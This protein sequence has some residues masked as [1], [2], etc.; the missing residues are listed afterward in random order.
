MMTGRTLLAIRHIAFEDLGSY[1]APLPQAGCDIAHVGHARPAGRWHEP[2][3]HPALPQPG[4][5]PRADSPRP[6][7]PFRGSPSALRAL[8]HGA[9]GRTWP[10]QASAPRPCAATPGATGRVWSR[11]APLCRPSGQRICDGQAV[12]GA[13]SRS[14]RRSAP[15]RTTSLRMTAG[16]PALVRASSLAFMPALTRRRLTGEATARRQR[17]RQELKLATCHEAIRAEVVLRP[18]V[19]LAE[20]R[21]WLLESHGAGPVPCRESDDWPLGDDDLRRGAGSPSAGCSTASHPPNART[22]SRMRDMHSRPEKSP[23]MRAKT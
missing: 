7:A 3:R 11:R 13:H 6:P 14:W 10:Q 8:A 2:R 5:L 15:A 21:A 16:L 12:F 9:R 22:A 19:T 4:F 23:I 17:N 20:A 18:D 1:A